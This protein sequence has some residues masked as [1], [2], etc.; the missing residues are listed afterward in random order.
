MLIL[1]LDV[2]FVVILR[3]IKTVQDYT[4]ITKMVKMGFSVLMVIAKLTE[5]LL[6]FIIF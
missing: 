5:E 6:M 3:R 1:L 2:L 4:Y